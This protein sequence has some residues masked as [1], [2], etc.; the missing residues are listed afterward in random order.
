V[1]VKAPVMIPTLQMTS[2]ETLHLH[3]SQSSRSTLL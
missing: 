2:H 3:N 1:T